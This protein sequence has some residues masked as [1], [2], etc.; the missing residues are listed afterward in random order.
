MV[1]GGISGAIV[2]Y[3]TAEFI[4]LLVGAFVLGAIGKWVGAVADGIVKLIVLIVFLLI[5]AFTRQLM[6]DFI[7]AIFGA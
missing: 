5:N 6:W 1:V 2:G 7:S 3:D 4:G